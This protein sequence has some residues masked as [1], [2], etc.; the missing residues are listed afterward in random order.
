MT[1]RKS[2]YTV[3]NHDITIQQVNE[4]GDVSFWIDGNSGY[5]EKVFDNLDVFP[6]AFGKKAQDRLDN[7]NVWGAVKVLISFMVEQDLY[8]CPKCQT[9]YPS[10]DS[11]NTHFAGHKCGNCARS[12]ATCE[13]G[14]D[15]DMKCLNPHQKSNAR[16]STKYQC[17]KCG[18][19]RKTTPTG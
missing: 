9:L 17:K 19:R 7:G 10:N 3:N 15:H 2:E 5:R 18:Y 16:I 1:Y 12:D 8:F 11:V 13:D 4:G 14:G 6:E